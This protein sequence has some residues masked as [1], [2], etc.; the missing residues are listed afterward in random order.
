MKNIDFMLMKTVTVYRMEEL[1]FE[2]EDGIII[3]DTNGALYFGAISD[4]NDHEI[5]IDVLKGKIRDKIC[6]PYE[7]NTYNDKYGDVLFYFSSDGFAF[8]PVH[9]IKDTKMVVDID[10]VKHIAER[11][12]R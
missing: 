2:K 1:N 10:A 9:I 8:R 6:I 7:D 5:T 11:H 12:S 3:S 4:I